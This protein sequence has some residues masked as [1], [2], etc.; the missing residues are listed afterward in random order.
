MIPQEFRGRENIVTVFDISG[1]LLQK[2]IIKKNCISLQN[3]H[4]NTKGVFIVKV[5]SN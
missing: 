2:S 5:N 3:I 4:K 1:K